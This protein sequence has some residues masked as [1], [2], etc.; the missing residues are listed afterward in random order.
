MKKQTLRVLSLVLVMALV[1]AG[2][3]GS[4][5]SAAPATST[6]PAAST[7]APSEP[8]KTLDW[9]KKDITLVSP[10]AAGGSADMNTRPVA[11]ELSRILDCNVV[12]LNQ[13]GG[14]ATIG[15]AYVATAK[16]DGYTF[17]MGSPG[18]LIVQPARSP[19]SYTLDNFDAIA[20]TSD[21]VF[22]IMVSKDF[23]ADIRTVD[24]H[25]RRLREKLEKDDA[26]PEYIL[27]KWGVGYYFT[28]K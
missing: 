10:Y 12:V 8:E 22:G 9:P 26:N 1:L 5:T 14:G 6:A 27:T 16:P 17:L 28:D 7:A 3:G 24:V 11:E 4:K 23:P 18:G 25:V 2:C 15:T 13:P 20:Q 19:V 21:S